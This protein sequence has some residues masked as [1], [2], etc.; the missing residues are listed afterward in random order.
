MVVV[1]FLV[2]T[3]VIFLLIGVALV[4]WRSGSND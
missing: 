4:P 1:K 3:Y 2:I